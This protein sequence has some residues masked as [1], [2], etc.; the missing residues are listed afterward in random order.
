MNKIKLSK[1]LYNKSSILKGCFHY[2]ENYYLYIEENIFNYVI[3]YEQ[4][5]KS[6]SLI[7]EQDFINTL[8][9]EATR[10]EI[11]NQTKSIRELIIARALASSEIDYNNPVESK[12]IYDES[13]LNDW[14]E[15]EN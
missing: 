15:N 7:S 6:A 12:K 9:E 2:T 11:Y 14:F 13:L 10:H 5:N 4:K 1:K 8:L 3:N